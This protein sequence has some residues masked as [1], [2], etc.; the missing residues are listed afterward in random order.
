[1][2]EMND[3]LDLL[4]RTFTDQGIPVIVGEYGCFGNNKTQEVKRNFMVDV[5]RAVYERNM[6]PILWDTQDTFYNRN[7]C[8]YNDPLMLEQMMA[9]L[10][11]EE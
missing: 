9:I 8:T 10:A 4:K 5:C 1:M 7:T 2:K 11:E 3:L 6:C